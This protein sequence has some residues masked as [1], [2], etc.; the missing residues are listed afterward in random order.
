M[1]I[2]LL[3]L[4][5]L[6]NTSLRCEDGY[7]RYK[8]HK[9]SMINWNTVNS[10]R[11]LSLNSWKRD[12]E[13]KDSIS[14]W[15]NSIR[16]VDLIEDIGT[17]LD[18][19][20]ECQVSRGDS[21]GIFFSHYKSRLKEGDEVKTGKNSY[22]WIQL[23]DG[24]MVRLSPET[25]ISFIEMNCSKE[26]IYFYARV[27]FGQIRWMP[28]SKKT[29]SVKILPETDLIFFP[30]SEKRAHVNINPNYNS[31]PDDLGQF[32]FKIKDHSL[33]FKKL[34]ELIKNNNKV[35]NSF[36][37]DA[38][39]VTPNSSVHIRDQIVDLI[40]VENSSSYIRVS[41]DETYYNSSIENHSFVSLRNEEFKKEPISTD[42]WYHIDRSGKELTE[43]SEGEN[44]FKISLF[45]LR[46][47][48][49]IFIAREL[50][51]SLLL[52]EDLTP[53]IIAKKFGIRLWDINFTNEMKLRSS[54]L[55]TFSNKIEVNNL[56]ER[57]KLIKKIE[58]R[59]SHF[60]TGLYSDKYF[61]TAM[62]KYLLFRK[63]R[64]GAQSVEEQVLN[65]SK[66][67]LWKEL[68]GDFE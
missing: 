19:V 11:W 27:N 20:G 10:E 63:Q 1:R 2:L 45:L 37:H 56:R 6:I 13:L 64:L 22:L 50:L 7:I 53:V 28:R 31:D 66:K 65:S 32:L 21:G 42:Q 61:I 68:N 35:I 58:A 49:T 18:C 34:N 41:S 15:N 44:L 5:L 14:N 43:F 12:R 26:K 33:K 17:V 47:T 8:N 60:L 57:E 40:V 62:N 24:T 30:L 4:I 29:F 59:G 46:R 55:D 9:N 67:T 54:F 25:S 48:P 16:E 39:L 51:L 52:K 38:L 23:L 36:R 3:F